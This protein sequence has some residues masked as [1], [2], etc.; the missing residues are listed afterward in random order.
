MSMLAF[1]LLVTFSAAQTAVYES[2]DN[3][4][5]NAY[6]VIPPES[7]Y[8]HLGHDKGSTGQQQQQNDED[9]DK[10]KAVWMS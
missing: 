10:L 4:A 6:N 1:L 3:V 5:I 2:V 9:F 8:L 7:G